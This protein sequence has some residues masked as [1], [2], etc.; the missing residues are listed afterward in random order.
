MNPAVIQWA[1][2]TA[3]FSV[4][5]AV[6]ALGLSRQSLESIE[7]G[8]KRP[9]RSQLLKMCAK[10][11]RS[12]LT[13]YMSSPPQKGDRGQDFRTLPANQTRSDDATLDALV[14]D[15]KSRQN[16]VRT[17]VEDE[18]DGRVLSFV[19]SHTTSNTPETVA[20]AIK[21][22]LKFE[23]NEYRKQKTKESA[24]SYLRQKAEAAG[25]FVLL[26]G[27]LGSHHSTISVESFRG[28]AVADTIAPFVVI[29]GQ[30]AKAAWSFTLLHELAHIWLGATGLSGNDSDLKIEKFCNDV[31]SWLLLP[32]IE[33]ATLGVTDTTSISEAIELIGQFANHRH[34]SHKMVAYNLFKLGYVQ[35]R[36]WQ[37]ID[38][39][40]QQRWADQKLGQKTKQRDSDSGPN[41]YIVRRHKLG[42]GLM[43]LVDRNLRAGVLTPVKA[44]IVLGVKPRSVSRL[45]AK[46]G[47]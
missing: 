19:A 17:L 43:E 14:R 6:K 13:F 20:A 25:V 37:S 39:E 11:R 23:L 28:F 35:H 2:E 22:Q 4:D 10:Y 47:A 9:S 18:E 8:G 12:L 46:D 7:A 41:Y 16:M 27:D 24:F 36:T 26:I 3:G 32:P 15:V 31:A 38:S 44:A 42:K 1:R 30:D 5:E 21:Q 33:L 34:V 29:N 45:L 40:L